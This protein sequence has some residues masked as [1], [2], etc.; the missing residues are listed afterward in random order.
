MLGI[1][2][3]LYRTQLNQQS[4]VSAAWMSAAWQ[5]SKRMPALRTIL[6]KMGAT[7]GGRPDKK[8]VEAAKKEFKTLVSE[9]TGDLNLKREEIDG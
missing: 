7:K 5:R 8:T 6:N 2:G 9:M 4:A 3:F 1:D